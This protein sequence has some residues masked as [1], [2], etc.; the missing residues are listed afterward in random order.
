MKIKRESVSGNLKISESVIVT[1]VKQALEEIDGV[2]SLALVPIGRKD[3]IL[4]AKKPK[5]ILI[6]NVGETIR[7]T[8]GLIVQHGSVIRRV[9]EE[10]QNRLKEEVQNM[11]GIAVYRVNVYIA[12]MKKAG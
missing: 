4:K 11:T 8:V 10:V 7:I 5:P 6:E 3:Y 9:A 12:G 1:I 2:A